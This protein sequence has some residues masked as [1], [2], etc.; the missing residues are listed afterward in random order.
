MTYRIEQFVR[1]IALPIIAEYEDYQNEYS[2]G[3]ELADS[4]QD[5][6]YVI[7]SISAENDRIIIKLKQ[8]QNIN[9]TSWS[10]T[11]QSYF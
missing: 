1:K 8:N 10:E 4:I 2:S 7:E 9:D 3:N 11:D 5:K 6:P